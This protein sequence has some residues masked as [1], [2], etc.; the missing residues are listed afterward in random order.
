MMGDARMVDVQSL[1]MEPVSIKTRREWNA[2]HRY[3]FI[4]G[5]KIGLL[6]GFLLG[7]VG[8]PLL[9]TWWAR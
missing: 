2:I 9:M 7:L 5:L 8:M 1:L 4:E 6:S 3:A